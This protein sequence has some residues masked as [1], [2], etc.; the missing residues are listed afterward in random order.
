MTYKSNWRLWQPPAETIEAI[1]TVLSSH[2]ETAK[3]LQARALFSARPVNWLRLQANRLVGSTV[4]PASD[5]DAVTSPKF[6]A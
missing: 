4:E 2:W 5:S 1:T 3:S 6:T